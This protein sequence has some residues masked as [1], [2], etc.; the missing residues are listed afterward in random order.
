MTLTEKQQKSQHYNQEKLINMNILPS[1]QEQIIEKAKFV[2]SPLG[3]SFEEQTENYVG[4]IKS[5]ELCTKK[6]N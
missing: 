6:M 5:L 1:N 2:Y 4:V 3:K